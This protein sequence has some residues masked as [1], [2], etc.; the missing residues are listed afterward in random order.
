M[1][2]VATWFGSFI[3]IFQ[4]VSGMFTSNYIASYLYTYKPCVVA[5]DTELEFCAFESINN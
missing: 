3:Y 4:P 2:V 5:I 1:Y